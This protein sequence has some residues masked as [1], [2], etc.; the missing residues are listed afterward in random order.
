MKMKKLLTGCVILMAIIP[1]PA[2]AGSGDNWFGSIL[3]N[4]ISNSG[5]SVNIGNQN[6]VNPNPNPRPRVRYQ[7]HPASAYIKQC[8]NVPHRYVD[9]YGNYH[10]Y[11]RVECRMI[12][13]GPYAGR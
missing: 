1:V 9:R 12:L 3:S 13:R 11:S 10:D 2:K 4:I 5:L 7:F 6:P 8:L